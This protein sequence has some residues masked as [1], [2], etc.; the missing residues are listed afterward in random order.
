MLLGQATGKP[1]PSA[2]LLI[3]PKQQNN[4]SHHHLLKSTSWWSLL[5]PLIWKW[6]WSIMPATFRPQ[7]NAKLS[8]GQTQ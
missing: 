5:K 1:Q 8:R 2:L 7:V 3:Q 6:E 4:H